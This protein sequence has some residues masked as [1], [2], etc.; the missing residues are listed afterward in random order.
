MKEEAHPPT[1]INMLAL[2]YDNHVTNFKQDTIPSVNNLSLWQ[3]A[4]LIV[5]EQA[6]LLTWERS[7]TDE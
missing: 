4:R 2:T 5:N 1:G 6:P 7:L 3:R